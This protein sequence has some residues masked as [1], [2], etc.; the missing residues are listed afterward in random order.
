MKNKLRNKKGNIPVFK[1]ILILLITSSIFISF[2]FFFFNAKNIDQDYR[3]INSKIVIKKIFNQ[4]CFSKKYGTIDEEK[5]TENNLKNCFKNF[6]E[7]VIFNI[8]IRNLES[9]KIEKKFIYFK[10]KNE[11]LKKS[12]RCQLFKLKN[13][14]YCGTYKFPIIFNEKN[15]KSSTKLIEINIISS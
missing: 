6:K 14:L 2:I 1:I 13:N 12:K 11:F 10:E 9:K 8:G 4:K 3:E 7:D 5:F 15:L